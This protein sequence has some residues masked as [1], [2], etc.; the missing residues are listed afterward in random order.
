MNLVLLFVMLGYLYVCLC[1]HVIFLIVS[2]RFYNWP[3]HVNYG[4]YYYYYYYILVNALTGNFIPS[5]QMLQEKFPTNNMFEVSQV[6]VSMVSKIQLIFVKLSP[7]VSST[8]LVTNIKLFHTC[9]MKRNAHMPPLCNSAF[10]SKSKM[11]YLVGF[12]MFT[13]AQLHS[14]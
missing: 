7:Q 4:N 6:F 11:L 8:N 10:K 1:L 3:F 5:F 13:L 2:C 9:R 14:L 12:E